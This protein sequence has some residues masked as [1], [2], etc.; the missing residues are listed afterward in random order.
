MTS[1]ISPSECP[2]DHRP[3]AITALTS[4]DNDTLVARMVEAYVS[5]NS[6]IDIFKY[7]EELKRARSKGRELSRSC[8]ETSR[9][10]NFL[11]DC[12]RM[13]LLRNIVRKAL[14]PKEHQERGLP[15]EIMHCILETLRRDML[16]IP[17]SFSTTSLRRVW[18]RLEEVRKSGDFDICLG[19]RRHIPRAKLEL[20]ATGEQWMC[21]CEAGAFTWDQK[22]RRWAC[23]GGDAVCHCGLCGEENLW[24]TATPRLRE[25]IMSHYVL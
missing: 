7:S 22:K 3:E 24:V 12:R 19:A 6:A 9:A 21:P 14:A 23:R 4:A 2:K 20:D 5:H 15:P 8:N 25:R 1:R 16:R 13:E 18:A 11:E 10:E 17:Y